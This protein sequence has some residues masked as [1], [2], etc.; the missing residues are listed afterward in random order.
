MPI[1]RIFQPVPLSVGAEI[2]LNESASHHLGRVL[3]ASLRDEIVLFNGHG[4]EY[5]AVITR[6]DKKAV[7]V[8]VGEFNAREAESPLELYLVQGISRGEKMDYTIQKAVELGVKKIIPVF[9]ERCNVKLDAE[10]REK[11]VQQWQSIVIS[12]CEQSGRNCVPEVMVPQ[13][14]EHWLVSPDIDCGFVLSP[15]VTTKLSDSTLPKQARVALLIGPEGGLS[16]A[17]M[18]MV[19]EKYFLPLNLGPRILRTETAALAAISTLQC[20]FGDMR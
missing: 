14:L 11:R 6:I 12:A 13:K 17:E 16:D 4:G 20:Y 3:R 5:R 1:S 18:A 8:E 2:S 15:H 7:T 9:T 19:A 10:R